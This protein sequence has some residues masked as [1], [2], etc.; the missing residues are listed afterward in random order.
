MEK[1]KLE[2]GKKYKSI[3]GDFLVIFIT[4]EEEPNALIKY[5]NGSYDLIR[6]E[7]YQ[8]AD[9]FEEIRVAD[10]V[11]CTTC[12]GIDYVGYILFNSIQEQIYLFPNSNCL[13]ANRKYL[14]KKDIIEI[15]K[16]VPEV[17]K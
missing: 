1:I 4:R 14:N 17:K 12:Q 8:E 6:Y 10:L 3:K 16:L 11:L 2:V 13:C 5:N 15:I 9:L 7:N